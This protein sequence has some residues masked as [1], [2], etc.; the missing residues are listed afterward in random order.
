V[1]H[2]HCLERIAFR[3]FAERLHAPACVNMH[4]TAVGRPTLIHRQSCVNFTGIHKS[5]SDETGGSGEGIFHLDGFAVLTR[6][7]QID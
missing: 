3:F 6:M 2:L 7:R 5:L 1:F 4:Q